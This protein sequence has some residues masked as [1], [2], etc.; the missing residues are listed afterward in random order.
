[1][2]HGN[3]KTYPRLSD[4]MGFVTVEQAITVGE[5]IMLGTSLPS[6][7][8]TDDA[9]RD[10]FP[11]GIKRQSIPLTKLIIQVDIEIE[12][13]HRKV[14]CLYKLMMFDGENRV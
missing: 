3:E 11:L 14:V 13:V 1:M 5:H 4:V 12:L 10:V 6:N 9:R 2:T 7:W 8:V